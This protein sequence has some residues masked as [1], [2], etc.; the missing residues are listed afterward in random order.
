MA[1]MAAESTGE[2]AWDAAR[3]RLESE[4][5]EQK[6]TIEEMQVRE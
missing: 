6:A 1:L 4:L 3:H 2:I 5:E